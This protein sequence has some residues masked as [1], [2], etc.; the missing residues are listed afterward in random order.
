MGETRTITGLTVTNR[1]KIAVWCEVEEESTK[2]SFASRVEAGATAVI[3]TRPIV[4]LWNPDHGG[5]WDGLNV[6]WKIPA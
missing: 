1:E 6:R 4:Q 2:L 3:E 5:I